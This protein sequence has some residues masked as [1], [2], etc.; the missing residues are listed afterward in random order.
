MIVSFH[1]LLDHLHVKGIFISI[2]NSLKSNALL[3]EG[4]KK[5]MY[6]AVLSLCAVF[7]FKAF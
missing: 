5:P 2:Q 6:I 3:L 7:L 4:F 1:I